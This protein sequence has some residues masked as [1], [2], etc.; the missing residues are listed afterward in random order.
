MVT[1][2]SVCLLTAL[3]LPSA[4]RRAVCSATAGVGGQR[5]ASS[6][7]PGGGDRPLLLSWTDPVPRPGRTPRARS[8]RVSP[9]STPTGAGVSFQRGLRGSSG[10]PAMPRSSWISGCVNSTGARGPGLESNDW[11]STNT[12][13]KKPRKATILRTR[14][15]A[16]NPQ[17]GA[18][19]VAV[20]SPDNL[21]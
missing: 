4:G 9:R 1:S 11:I 21:R 7:Q 19:A 13:A 10:D 18:G 5:P 3:G 15:R 20:G 16:Q 17:T 6:G 12:C 8:C 14:A 2:V